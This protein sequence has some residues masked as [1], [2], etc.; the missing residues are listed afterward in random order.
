MLDLINYTAIHV[1]HCI[2]KMNLF[3]PTDIQAHYSNEMGKYGNYILLLASRCQ[4]RTTNNKHLNN[5]S[6]T[7]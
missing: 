6:K 3:S 2:T 5:T 7:D 1:I 4:L